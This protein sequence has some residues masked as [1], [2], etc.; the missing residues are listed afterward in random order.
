MESFPTQ[1]SLDSVNVVS[2]PYFWRSPTFFVDACACPPAFRYAAVDQF[3]TSGMAVGLGT[4]STAYFAVI[5][6]LL[7]RKRE[8]PLPKFCPFRSWVCFES[9]PFFSLYESVMNV[10]RALFFYP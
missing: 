4:G 2:H 1:F 10:A 5:F 9:P 7:T 8:W 6:C 3:V